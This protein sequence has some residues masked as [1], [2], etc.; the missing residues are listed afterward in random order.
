MYGAFD[1]LARLWKSAFAIPTRRLLAMRSKRLKAIIG[2]QAQIYHF[3]DPE[4]MNGVLIAV[5]PVPHFDKSVAQIDFGKVVEQEK[6]RGNIT[7]DVQEVAYA[8]KIEETKR[9]M[10]A[11]A[12][13][14][15]RAPAN[16]A[17]NGGSAVA[18]GATALQEAEAGGQ[19]G[20]GDFGV[21]MRE[22]F[23]EPDPNA[24]DYHEK[25]VALLNDE[26]APHHHT[27][28]QALLAASPRRRRG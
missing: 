5:G 24:P 8:R 7:V 22:P 10:E 3:N 9:E 17:G 4:E 28:V 15:A 12:K 6:A 23:R 18:C 19:N 26:R 20:R 11:H 2:P 27:A 1:S 21:A 13:A 14:E 25:L 16:G